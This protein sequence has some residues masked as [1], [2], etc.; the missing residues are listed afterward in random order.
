M[1]EEG[2]SSTREMR[3]GE[4]QKWWTYKEMEREMTLRHSRCLIIKMTFLR[5]HI[6]TDLS[7]S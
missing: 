1:T 5:V 3:G 6:L 2:G 7:Q 4:R